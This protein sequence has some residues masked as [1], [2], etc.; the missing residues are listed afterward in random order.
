MKRILIGVLM[1][2]TLAS[3]R[4]KQHPV[5]VYISPAMEQK[6]GP[7]EKIAVLGT[8][9]AVHE[10][11]DPDKIAPKTMERLLM[12]ELGQRNDYKFI[13]P[14]LVEHVLVQKGWEERF[15]KFMQS[16]AKT[17]KVDN[18]FLAELGAELQCDAALIQVVDVWQKDEVDVTEN[19]TPATYVGATVTVIGVKD[20]AILFRAS[21]EDYLEGARTDT[22]D[23][24]LVTS[25]SGAIYSDLGARVHKAPPFDDVAVKVARALATSLPPR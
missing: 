22:A 20:G 2:A 8:A 10:T 4:S 13:A 15:Q 23:R 16:Y 21:D 12:E 24:S 6:G 11:D 5:E 1:L 14:S 3:C 7:V 9:S 19:S 18:A 17:D 25:Q